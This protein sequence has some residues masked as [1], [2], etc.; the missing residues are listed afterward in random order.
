MGV[1]S[2]VKVQVF[3]VPKK[4]WSKPLVEIT[5]KTEDNGDDTN[6][7]LESVFKGSMDLKAGN[8]VKKYVVDGQGMTPVDLNVVSGGVLGLGG[9]RV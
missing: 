2:E 3:A 5:L 9:A 4:P 1:A 6:D 8:Y 7:V